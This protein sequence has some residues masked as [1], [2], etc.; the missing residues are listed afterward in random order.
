MSFVSRA[1]SKGGLSRGSTFRPDK[2]DLFG[3]LAPKERDDSGKVLRE[4]LAEEKLTPAE[5][6]MLMRDYEAKGQFP[7]EASRRRVRQARMAAREPVSWQRK[8][9]E[10]QAQAASESG[11]AC[12]WR[13]RHPS[14]GLQMLCGNQRMRNPRTKELTLYCGF[15]QRMCVAVHP[16]GMSEVTMPNAHGLCVTH[17]ASRMHRRPAAVSGL[18]AVPGVVELRQTGMRN[19]IAPREAVPGDEAG[20]DGDGSSSDSGPDLEPDALDYVILALRR[21]RYR[22]TGRPPAA[23]IRAVVKVQSHFRRLTAKR[24]VARIRRDRESS[25]RAE[26]AV[27]IQKAFRARRTARDLPFRQRLTHSSAVSIQRAF[28]LHRF[29]AALSAD[30]VRRSAALTIQGWYRGVMLRFHFRQMRLRLRARIEGLHKARARVMVSSLMGRFVVRFRRKMERIRLAKQTAAALCIQRAYRSFLGWKRRFTVRALIAAELFSAEAANRIQLAWLAHKRKRASR[31]LRAEWL[32]R[33]VQLQAAAR[34]ML[35]RVK[36]RRRRQE[37]ES[38]W[39]WMSPGMPRSHFATRRP[40]YSDLF[41]LEAFTAGTSRGPRLRR[42]SDDSTATGGD[43]ADE[44]KESWRPQS[45]AGQHGFADEGTSIG[46]V[47]YGPAMTAEP[48]PGALSSSAGPTG[49]MSALALSQARERQAA[50]RAAT[51]RQH[52]IRVIADLERRLRRKDPADTDTVTPQAFLRASLAGGLAR[53]EAL[54]LRRRFHDVEFDGIQ[55]KKAMAFA[56]VLGVAL[57]DASSWAGAIVESGQVFASES[58]ASSVVPKLRGRPAQHLP[59]VTRARES[60]ARVKAM[61]TSNAAAVASATHGARR[62]MTNAG[63][64]AFAAQPDLRPAVP[65][66]VPGV[67]GTRVRETVALVDLPGGRG[68][69]VALLTDGDVYDPT[70]RKRG[71]EAARAQQA[72]LTSFLGMAERDTAAMNASACEDLA[73]AADRRGGGAASRASVLVRALAGPGQLRS[74]N[75]PYEAALAEAIDGVRPTA[76][77][78]MFSDDRT[79]LHPAAR[80]ASALARDAR[81]IR[82]MQRSMAPDASVPRPAPGQGRRAKRARPVAAGATGGGPAIGASGDLIKT[83]LPVVV[84]QGRHGLAVA[85]EPGQAYAIVLLALAAPPDGRPDP[86]QED[87]PTA[88][89]ALVSSN[90]ALLKRRWRELVRDI[91]IGAAVGAESDLSAADLDSVERC[92]SPQPERA[93]LLEAVL[94]RLGV[95]GSVVGGARRGAAGL[96]RTAPADRD[97]DDAAAAADPFSLPVLADRPPTSRDS[98]DYDD[99]ITGPALSAAEEEARYST[100]FEA[101]ATALPSPGTPAGATIAMSHRR[102]LAVEAR[103][104]A[105]ARDALPPAVVMSRPDAPGSGRVRAV[106]RANSTRAT[107]ALAAAMTMAE[108]TRR[109]SAEPLGALPP[110]LVWTGPSRRCPPYTPPPPIQLPGC[111]SHQWLAPSDRCAQCRAYRA[112]TVP[113]PPC[114]FH[115][116]ALLA[117]ASGGDDVGVRATGFRAA[118]QSEQNVLDAAAARAGFDTVLV[119]RVDSCEAPAWVR[120]LA[121]CE[122]SRG[123]AW[124]IGER[125]WAGHELRALGCKDLSRGALVSRHQVMLGRAPLFARLTRDSV[126]GVGYL[127]RAKS[128]SAMRAAARKRGLD[129]ARCVFYKSRPGLEE[130]RRMLAASAMGAAF[131]AARAGDAADGTADWRG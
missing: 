102:G 47:G 123:S 27:K 126:L 110:L 6:R 41:D 68:T 70:R 43:A 127:R 77:G 9:A 84:V 8:Q 32:R 40:S 90:F 92:L 131:E 46:D 105:A 82:Q 97:A 58:A 104:L 85:D 24:A 35:G 93:A 87:P 94:R 51:E 38:V 39:R 20:G 112:M 23:G 34:G 91:R 86:L 17:Y 130:E 106:P 16:G 88:L 1:E 117:L 103:E 96:P 37:L 62:A 59:G 57:F 25:T 79:A 98:D 53:R 72:V 99:G 7:A 61:M 4:L 100:R 14:T 118:K 52:A 75:E 115:A 36:A 108:G 49:S 129:L 69:A 81:S 22:S 83:G 64:Y 55:W 74:D 45:V 48:A 5:A 18:W 33:L 12:Q 28:R 113:Q 71:P 10:L 66:P 44:Q 95:A 19:Y 50:A 89:M 56:R 101:G 3:K 107:S 128:E 65:Q 21:A 111:P 119:I 120:A 78:G 73:R 124:A 11:E 29:A 114:T 15:H 30:R 42:A 54:S 26:A 60:E 116:G 31:A 13:G 76:S 121:L 63:T 109:M 67:R 80:P 122:D 2:L 125:V